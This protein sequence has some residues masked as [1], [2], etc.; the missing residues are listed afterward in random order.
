MI[1]RAEVDSFRAQQDRWTM[2]SIQTGMPTG[3]CVFST[4]RRACP[5]NPMSC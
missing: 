3:R 5:A 1:E 4:R 2:G